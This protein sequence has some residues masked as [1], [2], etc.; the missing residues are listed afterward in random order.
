[1]AGHPFFAPDFAVK[2]SGLTMAADVRNAVTSLTYDNSLD[3]ADMFTIH[4]NNA[5]LQFTDS[6]LFD[7]GKT[8]EVHMGYV[9]ELEPMILGEITAVSPSFPEGGAP[10]ITITGYDKS[11]RMRHN[12][13][14][15]TTF[16]MLNDSLIAAQFAAE[17]L[18]I[19]VIDPSPM[20]PKDHVQDV[21]DW[22]FLQYLADRNFFQLYARWDKLYFRFPRPQT[23]LIVLEWGK[24]LSSFNPRLSTSG[25]FGIEVVRGYDEQ[26]AQ[27]IVAIL[28]ALSLGSDL[29]NI[30]ERLGS[31]FVEQLVNLGR[32]SL[33]H[34]PVSN[35]LEANVLAAS[36]LQQLLQG[37]FE[38]S[39]NCIGIPKLRAGDMIEIR[40]VG[41]RFSG[42]YTLSKVT[43]AIDSNGYRTTFE[44]TQKYTSNLLQS[45]RTKIND[46]PPP[47]RRGKIEGVI[48]GKVF[49]NVSDP[50]NPGRV[51]LT[52]PHL[53]DFDISP[54]ARVA[55]L[56]AG[57]TP[58]D[59]WGSYFLP[60]IGDEVLVTFLQG[61][62]NDPIVIGSLWN[63]KAP[64]PQSNEGLNAKKVIKTKSGLQILFDE[65]PGQANLTLQN[66]QG[67]SIK[68]EME[69]GKIALQHPIGSQV[70]L[71]ADGTVSINAM[72]NLDLKST[73]GDINLTATNVK[74]KVIGTM[75]VS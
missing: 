25:Q 10:T 50:L 23:E 24:N 44:V 11:H 64:P 37:L 39:G 47:N 17:N 63:G 16:H 3:T 27:T 9:G 61:D 19:P 31:G 48:I 32:H 36:I 54:W 71:N 4:L 70:T 68:I 2:I 18:L 5:Q 74:V 73:A 46:A 66:R 40:G 7:V 15:V 6:A 72:G 8:V 29:D 33:R 62:L 59:S 12:T 28:P 41:K 14:P 1:M 22:A 75:D 20:P 69:S 52:Y 38:G 51:Q 34:Q 60:D 43:H 45:L 13:P 42:K 35:F 55:T 26:L 58:A 30:I 57:G 67:S 56:T 49:N 53:S 21:S 65:T